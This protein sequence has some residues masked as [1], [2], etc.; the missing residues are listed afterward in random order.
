L[1]TKLKLVLLP[2]GLPVTVIGKLPLGVEALVE[3]VSAL[4]QVGLQALFVKL[5]LAPDGKP[6]TLKVTACEIPDTKLPVIVFDP[7]APWV[8]VMFPLFDSV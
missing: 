2:K 5:A 1:T 7:D 6:E 8:T 4:E 3:I